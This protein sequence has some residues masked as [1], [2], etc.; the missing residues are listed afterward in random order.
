MGIDAPRPLIIP[1]GQRCGSTWLASYL[2]SHPRVSLARPRRPEP[3]VFLDP[4]GDADTWWRRCS[5]GGPDPSPRTGLPTLRW[6]LEKST[7]Y[8]ERPETIARIDRHLPGV[9]VVVVLRDPVERAI[10]NWRFSVANGLEDRDVDVALDPGRTGDVDEDPCTVRPRMYLQRGRFAELLHPW[11]ATFGD[12]MHIVVLEEL[13]A[14]ARE[15]ERL[16]RTLGLSPEATAPAGAV[17]ASL[18]D[19]P[20]PRS[21]RDALREYYRPLQAPLEWLLGRSLPWGATPAGRP[22][23]SLP[24]AERP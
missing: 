10:S 9:R 1:G 16:C 23:R 19:A 11:M 3:K 4:H 2:D 7:A 22:T 17:N 5:P 6:V 20:I 24:A 8:L 21:V 14:D 13:L 18:D 12:R 15:G